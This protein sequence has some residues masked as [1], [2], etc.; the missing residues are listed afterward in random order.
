MKNYKI[1]NLQMRRTKQYGHYEIIGEVNGELINTFTTDAE[2]F[3]FFND[4]D[5]DLRTESREHCEWKLVQAFNN[6]F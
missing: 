4:D 1:T 3:D 5:E 6:Q 2:A